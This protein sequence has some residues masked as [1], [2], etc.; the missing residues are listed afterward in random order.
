MHLVLH[1]IE[2]HREYQ[3]RVLASVDAAV[4]ERFVEVEHE[5]HGGVAGDA[6]GGQFWLHGPGDLE[7]ACNGG[8]KGSMG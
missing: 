2:F 5:R 3:V 1:S 6:A 8:R 7:P 4:H